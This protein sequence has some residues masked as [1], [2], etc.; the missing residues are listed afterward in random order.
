MAPI[1]LHPAGSLLPQVQRVLECTLPALRRLL[2][3]AEVEHVGAT[4]VP[5]ALTKG[6]VD[7]V[8]RVPAG[9]FP[10]AVEVLRSHFEVRQPENWTPAFASFGDDTRELPL[11]IQLVVQEPRGDFLTRM[12]DRL[13]ACP[14]ALAEYNAL[15]ARYAAEGP[16][17]YWGAKDAYLRR[18]LARDS[19]V[20]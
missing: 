9:E 20:P 12:R 18:I 19:L 1:V 11:G 13:R 8:V 5:G 16:E 4:A 17:A 3:T 2:P 14:E 7:V 10:L 6:D 15:K